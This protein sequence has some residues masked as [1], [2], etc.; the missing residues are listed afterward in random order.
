LRRTLTGAISRASDSP[1]AI[2]PHMAVPGKVR[3]K[4]SVRNQAGIEPG[5]QR[6]EN[7]ADSYAFRVR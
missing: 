7:A 6:P 5:A 3:G 1:A 2:I 4:S